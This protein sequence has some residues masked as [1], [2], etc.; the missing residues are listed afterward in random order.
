MIPVAAAL[1]NEHRWSRIAL[2]AG[3]FLALVGG[4]LMLAFQGAGGRIPHFVNDPFVEVVVPL[5]QG[6]PLPPW[7]TGERIDST[8]ERERYERNLVNLWAGDA[9]RKRPAA[10]QAVQFLPLVLVQ[11][12][13]I[14]AIMALSPQGGNGCRQESRS[15]LRVDQ[16]QDGRRADQDSQ[17]PQAEAQGVH[18]DPRP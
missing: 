1:A 3:L 2:V 8:V 9:I 11:G 6:K 15:D 4:M 17:D 14:L 18:P 10:W 13:G 7:W 5:W 12:L 16:Q